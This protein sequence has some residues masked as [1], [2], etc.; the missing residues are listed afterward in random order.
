MVMKIKRALGTHPHSANFRGSREWF[1]SNFP[2]TYKPNVLV[3][4]PCC[5]NDIRQFRRAITVTM[6]QR[7]V[8]MYRLHGTDWHPTKS[9]LGARRSAD[10]KRV[11]RMTGQSEFPWWGLTEVTKIGGVRH[12]RITDVGVRWLRGEISVPRYAVVQQNICMWYEDN[13][14]GN[15]IEFEDGTYSITDA[16]GNQF[17]LERLLNG[18][19]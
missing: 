16:M 14:A 18:T 2:L 10:G 6:A 13:N 5:G 19:L 12:Q 7:L 11:Y 4:C 9:G 17:D 3:R 1:E 8:E 15:E